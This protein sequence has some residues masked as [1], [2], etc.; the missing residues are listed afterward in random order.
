LIARTHARVF[1]GRSVFLVFIKLPAGRDATLAYLDKLNT[2]PKPWN[3]PPQKDLDATGRRV[4]PERNPD[5]PQFPAGTQVALVRQLVV[6]T[7]EGKLVATPLTES[8]QVRTYREIMPREKESGAWPRQAQGFVEF[9]LRR[10][11]LFAGK[12]GGLRAIKGDDLVPSSLSFFNGWVDPF[13]TK[14]E[15]THH[16]PEPAFRLCAGCHGGGGIRGVNS[17]TQADNPHPPLALGLIPTSVAAER[18]KS[19]E[20]K[21]GLKD[22][23]ALKKA[24]EW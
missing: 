9:E 22:W 23:V 13:E 17:Y 12:T 10:G 19:L 11:E 7:E 1:A 20:W 18:K 15:D 6:V 14:S 3:V 21:A 8:V 4:R 24:A 2:F 16:T 5:V